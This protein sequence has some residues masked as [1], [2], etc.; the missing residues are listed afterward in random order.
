[1]APED[2]SQCRADHPTHG[3][4]SCHIIGWFTALLGQDEVPVKY[5]SK[6]QGHAHQQEHGSWQPSQG[7]CCLH[8]SGQ[9]GHSIT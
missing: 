4:L 3:T 5:L 1:M 8:F 6:H 2:H 9:H 7:S